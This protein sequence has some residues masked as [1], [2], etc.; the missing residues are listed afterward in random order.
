MLC[1]L[2]LFLISIIPHFNIVPGFLHTDDLPIILFFLV[3]GAFIGLYLS[4]PGIVIS[5]NWE[6]FSEIIVKSK[7]DKIYENV[8]PPLGLLDR[9]SENNL[10]ENLRKLDFQIK[11]KLA[12]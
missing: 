11:S 8:L 12:A 6:C 3:L 2:V 7:E 1:G 10:M 4:W 9:D 5:R